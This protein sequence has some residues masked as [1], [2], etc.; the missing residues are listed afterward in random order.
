MDLAE[1]FLHLALDDD[2]AARAR[3]LGPHCGLCDT[4]GWTVSSKGW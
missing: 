3:L 4:P 2:P 1:S